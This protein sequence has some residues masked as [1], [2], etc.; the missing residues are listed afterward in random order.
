MSTFHHVLRRTD[1]LDEERPVLVRLRPG[2]EWQ[3]F[4]PDRYRVVSTPI[5]LGS[6]FCFV[7]ADGMRLCTV[8]VEHEHRPEQQ[9]PFVRDWLPSEIAP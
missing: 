2:D 5:A 9:P 1:A 3:E 8:G 6:H 4:A 7:S